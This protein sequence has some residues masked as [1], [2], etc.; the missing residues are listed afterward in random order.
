MRLCVVAAGP[1]AGCGSGSWEVSHASH[2]GA[3]EGTEDFV[4]KGRVC[5][6]A[7]VSVRV[8]GCRR[9]PS[10]SA[11]IWQI[12]VFDNAPVV[13]G[14]A[15]GPA[16]LAGSFARPPP[17]PLRGRAGSGGM[18][19]PGVALPPFPVAGGS[20]GSGKCGTRPGDVGGGRWFFL[21]V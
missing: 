17:D 15:V 4:H 14:S 12:A 5:R 8:A 18:T 11:W 13:I 1:V 2:K 7:S 19:G 6:P 9:L 21:R 16:R 20:R 3:A 10:A